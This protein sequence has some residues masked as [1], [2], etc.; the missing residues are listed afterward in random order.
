MSRTSAAQLR[1]KDI[2]VP[3]YTVAQAAV[4]TGVPQ[5]QI[6]QFLDREL[7]FLM[8]I[9]PGFRAVR[10][11]GLVCLRLNHDLSGALTVDYRLQVIKQV[12]SNPRIK[13]VSLPGGPVT[14]RTDLARTA[15]AVQLA[16]WRQT[17]DLVA[18]NEEV[19]S[20]EACLKGTRLSVYQL[21]DLFAECGRD[22]VRDTYPDVTDL[23]LE[24]A[25]MFAEMFP[26]KGR[27]RSVGARLE[28][29][30]PKRSRS[31]RVKLPS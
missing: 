29:A 19:M 25:V 1:S 11:E 3:S 10:K 15:V 13:C 21:S 28:K 8:T 14:V 4:L 12:M 30:K 6:N 31:V 20:G 27:P 7:H 5:K 22:E 9:G 24:A 18:Q 17:K 23:E 2:T 16:K 26:R